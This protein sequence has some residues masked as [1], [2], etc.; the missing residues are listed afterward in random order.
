MNYDPRLAGGPYGMPERDDGDS[1]ARKGSV[2]AARERLQVA[3]TQ[4]Q[5][6]DRSRI[7]GLPQRPNQLVSQYSVQNRYRQQQNLTPPDSRGNG[8]AFSPTPQWPLS[9]DAEDVLD[10]TPRQYPR[11]PDRGPPPQRPPRP[12]S[13]ELPIQQISPRGNRGSYQSDDMFSPTD[14]T[15]SSRPLT[16]S[17]AASTASSLGSIP[18]FPIPQP[19]M[20]TIQPLPRRQPSL[21]P[22]PSARRGP[23]SYYTQISY[24]SPIAEESETRSETIRSLHG[25]FASSNVIPSNAGGFYV[26]DDELRSE[27]DET[28][29]SDYG[30]ESIAASSD[31]DD[32]SGLVQP[33][34]VRQAS[35]GRRT[36]PSLMTI[37]SGDSLRENKPVPVKRKPIPEN[38]G[39][40]ATAAGIG[41]AM[42]AVRE[43]IAS[44]DS[45]GP[46]SGQSD[47]ESQRAL[48]P[49]KEGL[50]SPVHPLQQ[51]TRQ[52]SLADRVGKRRPPRINVDAVRDAEARGSLTSLPELIRRAT[53]LAANLDRGKTASRLG[54]D[55]WEAG[56]PEKNKMDSRRSGSLSDMLAA[57]PPPGD[58][59]PSGDRTPNKRISKWPSGGGY[60]GMESAASD[61]SDMKSNGRRRKCCGMPMWTFVTLLIVLLFL[62]AAA[63]VIPVVLIVVPRMRDQ[64]N[65][66]ANNGNNNNNNNNDPPASVPTSSSQPGQCDGIIT[67]QNGGV[68]I[69]NADRSCNCV[70]INGFTGRTC[71]TQGDAGC[72]TTNIAGT[73]N[74][75]TIGSGIPRLLSS[76]QNNFSVPLDPPRLLS[77]FSNLSLT[78]TS[79]NALVTFNG[80]AS[81]STPDAHLDI[82]VDSSLNPSSS[83]PLLD[84]PHPV[85]SS[86]KL[87]RRQAIGEIPKANEATAS[88]TPSQPIS[89]NATAIDFARIS[90]LLVLQET[91]KLDSAANAQEALQNFLS[92]DGNNRNGNTVNLG[93][94]FKI[95]L[96]AFTIEL[97]NGT[98]IEA[99]PSNSTRN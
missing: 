85:S 36:K 78:C 46:P 50:E 27:D 16:T 3:Q 42:V 14:V 6:P 23:S 28:V 67:C 12:T 60:R 66:A 65:T 47:S 32:R 83:I 43:G 74:N 38:V 37:R 79:E 82:L 86:R 1:N 35:L 9:S 91:R 98:T 73:A 45:P 76:A 93:D 63:V 19:P 70:C 8:N 26:E 81:R 59:T 55:F 30:G 24:V 40:S 62:I 17:S 11:S 95:D 4:G 20:P 41:G 87:D 33:A 97:G 69:L 2:R 77:L 68:A 71:A 52:T 7:V 58:A 49:E 39:T 72:T 99:E 80:L 13:D 64:Q 21:G 94:G 22:P 61:P 15:V 34:L 88:P 10:A 56:A 44:R 48:D 84:L 89:S 92:N 90:V 96:V 25:S 29:T 75:A 18:D 5:L 51:G 54:L 31:H 53:R 57:F